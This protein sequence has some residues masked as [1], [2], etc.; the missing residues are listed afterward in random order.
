MKRT[1][2]VLQWNR[3]RGMSCSH[4]RKLLKS[5]YSQPYSCHYLPCGNSKQREI[6]CHSRRGHD[7]EC[8]DIPF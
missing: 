2:W 1:D 8:D 4:Y 5:G 7:G 3:P 6:Y